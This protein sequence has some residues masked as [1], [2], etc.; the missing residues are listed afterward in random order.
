MT[1]NSV[2]SYFGSVR[3]R[4]INLNSTSYLVNRVSYEMTLLTR[5]ISRTR[6]KSKKW[7]VIKMMEL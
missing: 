6:E 4:K 5:G 1:S 3:L 7:I 2:P